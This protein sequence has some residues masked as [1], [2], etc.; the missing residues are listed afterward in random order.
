MADC[1]YDL[2]ADPAET[3]DVSA[4]HTH[5][6]VK[7]KRALATYTQYTNQSMSPAELAAGN[8]DCRVPYSADWPWL[9][10]WA[11]PCCIRGGNWTS[12]ER[13]RP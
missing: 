11:G 13:L 5:Q 3:T 9:R 8:W 2:L 12:G 6:V 4:N 1:L 7:L 10:N